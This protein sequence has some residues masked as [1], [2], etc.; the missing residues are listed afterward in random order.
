MKQLLSP[1]IAGGLQALLWYKRDADL[2]LSTKLSWIG[3]WS[4]KEIGA[5]VLTNIPTPSLSQF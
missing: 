3:L 2:N 5:Q 4:W 1:A